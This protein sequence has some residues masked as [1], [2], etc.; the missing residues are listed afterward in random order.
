[1]TKSDEAVLAGR[2]GPNLTKTLYVGFS[3]NVCH[4]SVGAVTQNCKQ[5]CMFHFKIIH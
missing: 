4:P 2:G 3:F 5:E 1:M